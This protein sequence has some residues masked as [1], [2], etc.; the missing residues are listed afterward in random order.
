MVF[1]VR[2]YRLKTV[3]AI[4]YLL[5]F[6]SVQVTAI[7]SEKTPEVNA[8]WRNSIVQVLAY[9][10]DTLLNQG[11]GVVI[12][13]D[14]IVSTSAHLLASADRLVVRQ[15]VGK[16]SDAIVVG[17]DDLSDIAILRSGG[18]LPAILFS[19]KGVVD[20][21]TLQLGGYWH[22]SQ[23]EPRRS[24]FG[25]SS[26]PKFIATVVPGR[27]VTKALTSEIDNDVKYLKLITS[28][29]R[30]AYGAALAN[31]C[32]QLQGMIRTKPGKTLKELWQP[33]TPLGA[34]AIRL[35]DLEVF[36]KK[37]SISPNKAQEPCLTVTEQQKA[38]EAAKQKELDKAKEK[39]RR[40]EEEASNAKKEAD[41]EK[42]ARED[43]EKDRE[44]I[45]TI[46]ED[47]NV[48]AEDVNAENANIK[49][50]NRVLFWGVIAAIVGGAF[51]VL[52]AIIKR[53]K[54]LAVANTAL[55][56]ASA[57]FNDCRFE[58]VDSSGAPIAFMVLGKD[59]MQ[60]EQG[61]TV[62]RNPEMAQVVI[63]DDTVSRQH[64]QLFVKDNYLYVRDLGSTG[65]TRIN[66][67]AAAESGAAMI[68]SDRVEFGDT[69]FTMTVLEGS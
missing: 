65:G 15:T 13:D 64:A 3:A 26:K 39:A 51:L 40:A 16:E 52:L 44:E 6:F 50:D 19:Q 66:G 46:V 54:D 48:K 49:E 18:S 60:R 59:I 25:L 69:Q 56:A 67:V 14:G 23:E 41:D 58:G 47:I 43:A 10:G 45:A 28:V 22:S 4:C 20:A 34:F 7:E 29:G 63:A 31:R 8:D 35:S 62:G 57:S 9:K 24:L 1:F 38:A 32:G 33:H 42:R 21:S 27:Q 12:T 55:K 53:R 61:L 37:L 5:L 68:S 36:L 17:Q 30:G 11:S 2:A